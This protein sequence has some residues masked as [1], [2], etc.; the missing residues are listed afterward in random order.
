MT[1]IDVLEK[2]TGLEASNF[3]RALEDRSHGGLSQSKHTTQI[4][5]QKKLDIDNICVDSFTFHEYI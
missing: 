3:Q 4:I 1:Y 5:K 2:Y